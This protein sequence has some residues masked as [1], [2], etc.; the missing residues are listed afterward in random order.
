MGGDILT[1]DESGRA[2]GEFAS[3]LEWC[4]RRRLPMGEGAEDIAQEAALRLWRAMAEGRVRESLRAYALRLVH[5][6]VVDE[7]RRRAGASSGF[8]RSLETPKTMNY[9]IC[10]A[11]RS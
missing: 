10:K 9:H 1:A 7:Y 2:C 5:N 11:R 3:P 8:G 4:A 6:L